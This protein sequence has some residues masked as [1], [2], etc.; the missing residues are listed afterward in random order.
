MQEN[1]TN[2]VSHGKDSHTVND[3]RVGV[4]DCGATAATSEAPAKRE[5]NRHN[6]GVFHYCP[7]LP[8][9]ASKRLCS[10]RSMQIFALV[11]LRQKTR[12]LADGRSRIRGSKMKTGPFGGGLFVLAGLFY[13][14]APF[15]GTLGGGDGH[16]ARAKDLRDRHCTGASA[17]LR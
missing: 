8:Q 12:L 7:P 17:S 3:G 9:A 14:I 4:V 5:R 15:T 11:T 16:G 1:K 2:W 13:S 10:L 6:D